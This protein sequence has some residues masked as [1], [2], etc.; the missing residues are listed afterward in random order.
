MKG[1]LKSREERAFDI[2]ER[3]KLDSLHYSHSIAVQSIALEPYQLDLRLCANAT[4][5]YCEH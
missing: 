5:Y 3:Q 2:L 4:I 1:S